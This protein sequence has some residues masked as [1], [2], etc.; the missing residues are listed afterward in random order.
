M[1][2]LVRGATRCPI[3]GRIIADRDAAMLFPAFV[4]NERDPVFFF[5]DGAF[6]E[7]C[8]DAH[9]DGAAARKLALDAVEHSRPERRA[10]AVCG[11]PIRDPDDFLG[12]GYLTNDPDLAAARFNYLQLHRS[13][14]GR[15]QDLDA[16][17]VALEQLR[18][19]GRWQGAWLATLIRQLL[20]GRRQ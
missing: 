19:S 12:F 3:C 20:D 8:V 13:H 6:H 9:V 16:A 14:I 15:W 11:E 4:A 7:P 1:A 17:V 18:D 10:C 5:S 2:I